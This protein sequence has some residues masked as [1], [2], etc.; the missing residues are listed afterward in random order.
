V[1]DQVPE[2]VN[3]VCVLA[4]NGLKDPD[5]AISHSNNQMKDGLEPDLLTLAKA[6][7]F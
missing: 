1:K 2:G 7:G 5:T 6:M 3:N 4:G